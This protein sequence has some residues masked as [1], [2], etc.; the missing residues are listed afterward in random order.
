M[1]GSGFLRV[2]K[3]FCMIVVDTGSLNLSKP[4]ERYSKKTNNKNQGLPQA[5]LNRKLSLTLE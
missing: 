1:K 2:L 4:I 3:L 5:Q